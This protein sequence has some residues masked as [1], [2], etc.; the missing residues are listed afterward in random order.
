MQLVLKDVS[1]SVNSG[2][3]LGLVGAN[4]S[5][6]TTLMR[7]IAGLERPD[8]GTVRFNPSNLR[9]GY[10]AQG[11]D[12]FGEQTLGEYLDAI[13]GGA[14]RL[15]ARLEDL[16]AR[17]ADRP[18]DRSLQEAYDETLA[19][20][21]AAGQSSARAESIL[22]ALG[23]WQLPRS[24]AA[25]TLSGGQKTRLAL[26]G[27]L[28]S[29]PQLLLLDEPTNHLDLGMLDWLEEWLLNQQGAVLMVSHDRAFLDHS[30]NGILELD[31]LAHSIKY[32]GGNYTGYQEQRLAEMDH[33]RQEYL[34]QQ[35]EIRRLKR[36]AQRIRERARP[37]SGPKPRDNDK[38]AK[39]FFNNR[40][41][42]LM[43]RAK[44][45]ER[46]VEGMLNEDRIKKP[47]QAWQMKMTFGE[48]LES[49]RDV[50]VME[51]LC[52]GYG[53][54]VLLDGLNATIRY[55]ERV[56]LVGENGVGKTTLLRTLMGEVAPLGGR[57]RFG[58]Q[59]KPG[60]MAQEE[61]ERWF[62]VD[63]Y[64]T[65]AGLTRLPETE[66]RRLL[67]FYLFTNDE[68][69][70]PVGKLSFGEQ[71][72]LS[73]ACLVAQGCNLLLLDEPTNH[74]DIPARTRFEDALEAFEGTLLV[75]SHDRYFIGQFASQVWEMDGQKVRMTLME[76][77]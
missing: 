15:G 28:V 76:P 51:N 19:G 3:R 2:E 54:N 5:G 25:S 8:S 23:L 64:T 67:S 59:V 11:F 35:D 68:V 22:P 46:R 70:T 43:R 9:V 32:Y 38:F 20:L 21:A 4:G 27:V 13:Q 58:S 18:E 17:L 56:A 47:R 24:Q 62:K 66:V 71:A 37:N 41:L 29:A 14:E 7:I 74:L 12:L 40:K 60:Y 50:L 36:A 34:D 55:G 48:T 65:I 44:G 31:G 10:L 52:I 42:E 45:V 30:A 33:L 75:I 61:Q 53:E 69:F 16:A 72:R 26:A 77:D 39:G 6:K 1:F 57:C 49:G 63:P 73:L